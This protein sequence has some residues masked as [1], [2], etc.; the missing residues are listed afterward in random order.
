VGVNW[1]GDTLMSLPALQALRDNGRGE[2]LHVVAPGPLV[3][4]IRMAELADTVWG[5]PPDRSTWGRIREVRTRQYRRAILFP[6]AFRPAWI[7]R[8][9]GVRERW[10]YGGQWRRWLLNRPIARPRRP[11]RAHQSQWYLD[12]ARAL[13]WTGSQ[14]PKVRLLIPEAGRRWVE[15]C[16]GHPWHGFLVGLCPGA[17][18]GPAKRWPLERFA[19]VARAL[20]DGKGARILVL[21]SSAESKDARA[22]AAMI[23]WG[24]LDLS[25]RTDLVQLAAALAACDLVVSNDSGPMHLAAAVGTRVVALFGSTD[26]DATSPLGPHRVVRIPMDCSPCLERR[27]RDGSYR[28]LA[29]ISPER[30]LAEAEGLLG[31]HKDMA[32]ELS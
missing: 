17:A 9:A 25:G 12:I 15:A 4:L 32:R 19:H 27:C 26:P 31:E 13:G 3:P 23:G 5:W 10:G 24:V 6:N 30:V 2:E 20:R 11:G 16:V 1:L 18:Y 21:G 8:C 28:C 29:A 7:V 14:M 22:L